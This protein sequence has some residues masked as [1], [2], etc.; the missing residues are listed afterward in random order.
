MS[1]SSQG[2]YNLF[3]L[4]QNVAAV[5]TD[6]LVGWLGYVTSVVPH[7]TDPKVFVA[8]SW[9]HLE[10]RA[11]GGVGT[12]ASQSV[13]WELPRTGPKVAYRFTAG[14]FDAASG[15]ALTVSQEPTQPSG[16]FLFDF[17]TGSTQ[18]SMNLGPDASIAALATAG[19]GRLFGF[20]GRP[21]GPAGEGFIVEFG[22]GPSS[23]SYTYLLGPVS[24]YSGAV[25]S[26]RVFYSVLG[27]GVFAIP[28]R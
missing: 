13:E 11:T 16:V 5:R 28:R 18:A 1:L 14:I 20:G 3:P 10:S 27:Q 8:G 25:S 19:D 6:S 7:P 12:L 22:T 4:A 24:P 23:Q 2:Y 21:G 26:T 15:K 17:A 9:V